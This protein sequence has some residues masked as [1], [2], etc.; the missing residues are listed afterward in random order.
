MQRREVEGDA[1]KSAEA[2]DEGKL[3]VTMTVGDIRALLAEAAEKGAQLALEQAK[4]PDESTL[5]E[6]VQ[7]RATRHGVSPD[8]VI[9]WIDNLGAPAR[10]WSRPG[11]S[12]KRRARRTIRIPIDEFDDW[13][14]K[15]KPG[16][17]HGDGNGRDSGD[18]PV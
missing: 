17:G 6:T 16:I 8:T 18:S 2:I 9:Y 4:P 3:V 13:V 14:A 12:V 1:M 10:I 11:T 7:K 5:W 15:F